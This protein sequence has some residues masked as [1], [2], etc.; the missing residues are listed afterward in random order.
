[1]S[2]II[3]RPRDDKMQPHLMFF[4][5]AA[6]G[7]CIHDFSDDHTPTIKFAIDV[8]RCGYRSEVSYVSH[9]YFCNTKF[10]DS[11][12][13]RR[14]ISYYLSNTSDRGNPRRR[15]KC[16]NHRNTYPLYRQHTQT[17]LT[18]A[19]IAKHAPLEFFRQALTHRH[20][21]RGRN[22]ITP[23]IPP[24]PSASHPSTLRSPTQRMGIFRYHY[25]YDFKARME[26]GI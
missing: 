26:L 17:H 22:P 11:Y 21:C 19:R 20:N 1:M 23:Y 18:S 15:S 25:P 6:L 7:R 9:T 12:T 8:F 2:I 16:R 5:Y 4:V 13:A 3:L 10:N 24:S 14:E